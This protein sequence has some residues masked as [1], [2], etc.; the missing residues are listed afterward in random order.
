MEA[1]AH[2]PSDADAGHPCSHATGVGDGDQPRQLGAAVSVSADFLLASFFFPFL[3][4]IPLLLLLQHFRHIVSLMS[5]ILS[6][7]MYLCAI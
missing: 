7:G 1:A 5:H 6:T 4:L 3:L 2:V